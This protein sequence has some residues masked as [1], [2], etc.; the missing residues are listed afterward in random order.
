MECSPVRQEV[1][2]SATAELVR[3][4]IGTTGEEPFDEVA[5]PV[6]RAAGRRGGRRGTLGPD[7]GAPGGAL[8]TNRQ[9]AQR[10]TTRTTAGRSSWSPACGQL[11][12]AIAMEQPLVVVVEGVAVGR[13]IELRAV[14]SEMMRA[15]SILSPSCCSRWRGLDDRVAALLEGIVRV[16]LKGLTTDEQVRLVET[17][18]R[19]AGCG[20]SASSD[21]MRVGQPLLP[22]GDDRRAPRA[23][24]ARDPGGA[25]R[26]RPAPQPM[27][28]R[29]EREQALGA[30]R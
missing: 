15:P 5:Q 30:G 16:E 11:L 29:S 1:P 24:S 21:A 26:G 23:R 18:R 25:G 20:A 12:A 28:A 9:V 17:P 27:L 10:T 4:A 19:H 2:F 7:G 3:D 14:S 22:A 6:A 13:Q 8:A